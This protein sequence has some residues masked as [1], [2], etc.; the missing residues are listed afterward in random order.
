MNR[1]YNLSFVLIPSFNF[2]DNHVCDSN[3]ESGPFAFEI[4]YLNVK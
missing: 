3:I 2:T 4:A 1:V